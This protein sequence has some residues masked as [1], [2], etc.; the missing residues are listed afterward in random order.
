MEELTTTKVDKAI[1]QHAHNIKWTVREL[2]GQEY[3]PERDVTRDRVKRAY[4]AIYGTDMWG[5]ADVNEKNQ[6]RAKLENAYRSVIAEEASDTLSADRP[7]EEDAYD[8]MAETL[9]GAKERVVGDRD[10]T[11]GDFRE[12]HET[13]AALWSAYFGIDIDAVDVTNAMIL[14]KMS[15]EKNG[16][17]ELDHFRDKAGYSGI[18]AG[19]AFGDDE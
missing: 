7:D 4:D 10:E 3:D 16:T 13:I 15:R 19:L 8:V 1:E 12:N 18:G 5:A 14:L 11:H 9:D 17:R 6:F 2:E